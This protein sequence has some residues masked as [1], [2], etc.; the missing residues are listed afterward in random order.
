MRI[1]SDL[2]SCSTPARVLVYNP[3][4]GR[5]NVAWT[6]WK[7]NPGNTAPGCHFVSSGGLLAC[8][9]AHGLWNLIITAQS[10]DIDFPA[11][12]GNP[13]R[14][15]IRLIDVLDTKDEKVITWV[16]KLER[17]QPS[18]RISSKIRQR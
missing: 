13:F 14:R 6:K 15:G 3:P 1:G 17:K 11:V 2:V 12:S 7:R 8:P 5:A 16:E 9:L 18:K 10:C 4:D